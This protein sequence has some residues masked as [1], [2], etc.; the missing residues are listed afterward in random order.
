M[1][2]L[3]IVQS[4]LPICTLN[5]PSTHARQ[6]FTVRPGVPPATHARR[7]RP[8]R[9]EFDGHL[10]HATTDATDVAP[11]TIEKVLVD[12]LVHNDESMTVLYVPGTHNEHGPPFGPLAPVLQV[13]PVTTELPTVP[14]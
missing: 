7:V 6:G 5:V 4:A 8:P 10:E 3:Q 9:K 14:E 1:F 12:Q 11:V 13:Q 2:S